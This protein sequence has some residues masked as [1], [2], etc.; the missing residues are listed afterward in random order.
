MDGDG[1]FCGYS[2]GYTDYPY[3]YFADLTASNIWSY[4]VCVSSC[5]TT[6]S[7]VDCHTNSYV[8]DC[9]AYEKYDTYNFADE[10]CIPSYDDLPEDLKS[11]YLSS[12]LESYLNSAS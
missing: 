1:N 10:Y 8:T 7:T 5:P 3:L 12:G 9:D 6:N 4:A 11:Y 2:D